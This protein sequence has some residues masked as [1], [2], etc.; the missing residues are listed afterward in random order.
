MN[1]YHGCLLLDDVSDR[2][3]G[4]LSRRYCISSFVDEILSYI[5]DKS[6]YCVM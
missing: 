3:K 1:P 4:L 5:L 6:L 2:V